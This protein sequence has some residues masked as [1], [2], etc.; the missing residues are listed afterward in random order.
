MFDIF[1]LEKDDF[2]R[3]CEKGKF[4]FQGKSRSNNCMKEY[5]QL[6][7]YEK[8]VQQKY[9]EQDKINTGDLKWIELCEKV[10][11]RDKRECQLWKIL[12]SEQKQYI[13]DNYED[14]FNIFFPIIDHA[15]IIPRSESQSKKY[16]IN[17]VVCLSRYFHRLL[18][19]NL[20]PVIKKPITQ[21][22]RL[23]WMNKIR[24]I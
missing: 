24:G 23:D 13:K 16:D 22:E 2:L 14:E 6:K 11:I 8:Y 7:C 1:I 10:D 21:K 9:K 4:C 17:N 20:H 5:K 3:K 12:L 18:D 15:H 19:D